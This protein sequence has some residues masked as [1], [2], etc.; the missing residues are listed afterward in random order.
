MEELGPTY[1]KLGQMLS[2]RPDL[3]PEP[4]IKELERLQ[5]RVPPFETVVAKQIIEKEWAMQAATIMPV[6][7]RRRYMA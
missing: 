3:V 2:N 7:E 1:I 4:L 5:D 6:G